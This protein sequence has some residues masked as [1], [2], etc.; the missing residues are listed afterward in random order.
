MG[1][2]QEDPGTAEAAPGL[3]FGHEVGPRKVSLFLSLGCLGCMIGPS[4]W[5]KIGPFF[6]LETEC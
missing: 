1:R 2:C 5:S 6:G 4:R 3:F